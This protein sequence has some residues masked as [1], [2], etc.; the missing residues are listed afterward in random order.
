[1]LDRPAGRD[2]RAY[3][4]AWTPGHPPTR[5][6]K[7]CTPSGWTARSTRCSELTA[8]WGVTHP[9]DGGLPLVPRRDGRRAPARGARTASAVAMRP[10]TSRSSRTATATGCVSEPGVRGA[11]HP[12]PRARRGERALRDRPPR[13]RRR[14][15]RAH[16]RRGAARAIRRPAGWSRCCRRS[17]CS[18]RSRPLGASW[19]DGTLRLM[20]AEAA[21]AAARR[22]GRASP[23]WPTSSS[24][25]PC[26]RGSRRD[27]GRAAGLARRAARP[28]RSAAR[29]RSSTATRPATGRSTRSPTSSRCRA[30]PSPP[31][32]PTLVGEP[33]MQYVTR[34]RM[35]LALR[36]ADRRRRH[37]RRARRPARLPLRGRV[38]PRL[39][40]RDRDAA[41]RGAPGR[42]GRVAWPRRRDRRGRPRAQPLRAAR[43]RRGARLG[44]VPARRA[45]RDHRPHRGAARA[46]RGAGS[47][48][49]SSAGCSRTCAAAASP[50]SRRARSPPP[51][52]P[53]TRS[54]PTWW[55]RACAPGSPDGRQPEAQLAQQPGELLLL[56]PRRAPRSARA[57]CRG[58]PRSSRRAPRAR[59]R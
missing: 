29:S 54:T 38:R 28:P 1:M 48:R 45:Q 9:A 27:P 18:R 30:P 7:R 51:S 53:A 35:H 59:P 56:G 43:R 24:S 20:A 57:R 15:H 13:R 26:A 34:W 31:A 10:G 5:S 40:A 42:R 19:M 11:R 25:R 36:R 50:R 46:A 39:Q 22:R 52:S 55:T 33:A 49:S 47:A 21:R 44:G 41:G 14:V 6:A 2:G 37:R 32:S 8:P 12:R 17:C 16:L 3:C 58:A 23:G 4:C